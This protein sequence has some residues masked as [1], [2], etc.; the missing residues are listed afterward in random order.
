MK[1]NTKT[2]SFE[3]LTEQNFKTVENNEKMNLQGG[4]VCYPTTWYR[5]YVMTGNPC[6]PCYCD[7]DC[8][9]MQD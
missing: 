2:T 3:K 7:Q 1:K 5:S 4:Y 8:V 6:Y 9:M